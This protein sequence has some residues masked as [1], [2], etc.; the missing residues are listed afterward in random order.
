MED[1]E[2]KKCCDCGCECDNCCECDCCECDCG[3]CEK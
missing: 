1:I 2:L 3:K